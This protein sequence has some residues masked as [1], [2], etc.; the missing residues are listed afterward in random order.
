GVAFEHPLAHP[1]QLIPQAIRIH[2]GAGTLLV[3]FRRNRQFDP[4]LTAEYD[5]FDR[6]GGRRLPKEPGQLPRAPHVLAVELDNDIGV[7]DACLLSRAVHPNRNDDRTTGDL[8]PFGLRT[9]DVADT[10]SNPRPGSLEQR[11]SRRWE[12]WRRWRASLALSGCRRGDSSGER[13]S[14]GGS[15]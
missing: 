13:Q 4:L 9:V 14:E 11:D 15:L 8:Q 6:S 10:R 12:C 3:T 5:D 7:S 1:P 2:D